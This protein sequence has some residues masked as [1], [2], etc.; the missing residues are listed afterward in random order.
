MPPE[1]EIFESSRPLAVMPSGIKAEN[2]S[3]SV[4]AVASRVPSWAAPRRSFVLNFA[5]RK[6]P[7]N[8]RVNFLAS[9]ATLPLR[10]IS[11][12]MSAAIRPD[13]GRSV[14]LITDSGT[15]RCAFTA[16][17]NRAVRE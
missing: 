5:S 17:N 2:F 8:L 7:A 16:G 4:T 3:S 12:I 9:P 13:S 14:W 10:S 15:T 11:R 1:A 6:A